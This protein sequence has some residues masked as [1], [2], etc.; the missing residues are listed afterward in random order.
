MKN[1]TLQDL[2]VSLPPEL[3]S[4]ILGLLSKKEICNFALVSWECY[5][6]KATLQIEIDFTNRKN[7]PEVTDSLLKNVIRGHPLIKNIKSY[8]VSQNNRNWVWNY[9]SKLFALVILDAFKLPRGQQSS[10]SDDS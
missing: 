8:K 10:L 5:Q 7:F 1:F 3:L 2:L 4:N 6:L 9:C